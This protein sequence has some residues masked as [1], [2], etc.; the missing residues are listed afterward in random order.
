M[1]YRYQQ[2]SNFNYIAHNRFAQDMFLLF[3]TYVYVYLIHDHYK[4][5]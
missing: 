1:Y 4:Y 5:S 2:Y 3:V